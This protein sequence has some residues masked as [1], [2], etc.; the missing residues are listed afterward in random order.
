M[1]GN[2]WG[3]RAGPGQLLS[4]GPAT[5]DSVQPRTRLPFLEK[6]GPELEGSCKII[7]LNLKETSGP[8]PQAFLTQ[9]QVVALADTGPKLT[10][11]QA[12]LAFSEAMTKGITPF[13][14]SLPVEL[15]RSPK[16]V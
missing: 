14:S 6:Q 9:E 3:G 2:R 13:L 11:S 4:P 5:A 10:T 12:A 7:K 8:E 16:S 15:T 1:S